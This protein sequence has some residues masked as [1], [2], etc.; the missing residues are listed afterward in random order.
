MTVSWLIS[1]KCLF[2]SLVE[3]E[4]RVNSWERKKLLCYRHLQPVRWI[5]CR[6]TNKA[7]SR[8]ARL[9]P[10][11]LNIFHSDSLR[12][13]SAIYSAQTKWVQHSCSPRVNTEIGDWLQEW[14]GPQEI[15]QLWTKRFLLVCQST[16]LGL[17]FFLLSYLPD[18][19]F[20]KK[21]VQ[22]LWGSQ[23][24]YFSP[25]DSTRL[26]FVT[27]LTQTSANQEQ[28]HQNQWW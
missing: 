1:Q 16:H 2:F 19:I 18:D 26:E 13:C 10:N 24:P 20:K 27:D 6:E 8:Q 11:V 3:G 28:L 23:K 25:C 15:T 17:N 9:K 5:L 12:N 4:F 21:V 7:Q 22:I 14:W